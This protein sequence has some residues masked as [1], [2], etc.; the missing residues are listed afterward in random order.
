MTNQL[1]QTLINAVVYTAFEYILFSTDSDH[2]LWRNNTIPWTQI[3]LYRGI[4]GRHHMCPKCVFVVR[5]L[6]HGSEQILDILISIIYI[7]CFFLSIPPELSFF[8][9]H[10]A[11][12]GWKRRNQNLI[13]SKILIG[14]KCD[15]VVKTALVRFRRTCDYFMVKC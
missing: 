6:L 5:H 14:L 11:G 3:T 8:L 7:L 4:L 13:N 15:D 12:F 10:S 9:Y 2:W 1:F